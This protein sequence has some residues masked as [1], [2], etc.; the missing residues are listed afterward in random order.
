[1]IKKIKKIINQCLG[2]LG[3]RIVK[4]RSILL[5]YTNINENIK[6]LLR[7]KHP[8]IF[9]LGANRGQSI[10]RFKKIFPYSQIYCFEPIEKFIQELT[11][12]YNNDKSIILNNCGVGDVDGKLKFNQY[13]GSG[14]SSFNKI[15]PGTKW[16]NAR[17]GKNEEKLVKQVDTKIVTLDNYCSKNN[18]NSINFLKI[19]V[20]GYESKVL[21]GAINL[22]KS[23]IIDIIEFEIHHDEI[24]ENTQNMYDLE[25]YLI[26]NGY[27]LFSISNGGSL[28]FH[29]TFKYEVLYISNNI[30]QKYKENFKTK[31]T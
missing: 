6:F 27:K 18:I 21:K 20:Q 26:P 13:P 28:L 14:I 15:I 31:K 12:A 19:D 22:L 2:I 3:Y 9:D 1:M 24:Y 5:D 11:A 25:Q 23:S 8:V 30:Y 7:D 16:A 29:S 17:I 4:K 10:K